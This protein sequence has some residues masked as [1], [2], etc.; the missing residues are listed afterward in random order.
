MQA[1]PALVDLH[2]E[3]EREKLLHMAQRLDSSTSALSDLQFVFAV[4]FYAEKSGDLSI[5]LE[6]PPNRES[7]IRQLCMNIIARLPF[8]PHD[9]SLTEEG[10]E[11]VWLTMFLCETIRR[12][13]SFCTQEDAQRLLQR[14]AE[15]LHAVERHAWDGEWYLRGWN[16][17][18][19]ALGS[20]QSEGGCPDLPAQCWGVMCGASRDRCALAMEHVWNMLY[21]RKTGLVRLPDFHSDECEVHRTVAACWTVAALHQLGED[22]RA[23]EMALRMSPAFR[24]ASRQLA[25]RFRAEPYMIPSQIFTQPR[26]R[27]RADGMWHDG[28]AAWFFTVLFHQLL[29]FRKHGETLRFCPTAPEKWESLRITF[30]YGRST[31]HLHASRQCAVPS[32]D[33]ET[34]PG[35]VLQLKDD[36][37]IHEAF[38][39]LR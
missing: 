29:G 13:V 30:R 36:G 38:F 11:S 32:A 23:W 20:K 25:A 34:L 17:R 4:S 5:F 28:S 27:G 22:E 7:D 3:E 26:L 8:G 19:E 35:D 31:Y 12:F 14:R 6:I 1:L 33:G 37:R 18:G 39:P 24:S 9:V 10:D 16:E 2:S 15:I 21:D